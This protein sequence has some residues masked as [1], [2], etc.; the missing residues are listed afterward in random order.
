MYV[1]LSRA[2]VT[3]SDDFGGYFLCN[4]MGGAVN[5]PE[6]GAL[7]SLPNSLYDSGSSSPSE[8]EDHYKLR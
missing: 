1:S 2:S 5:I 8:E 6:V 7:V 4:N 3:T